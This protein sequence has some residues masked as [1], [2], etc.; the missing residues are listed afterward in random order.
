MTDTLKK[1][2]MK[3]AKQMEPLLTVR[4]LEKFYGKNG[5]LSKALDGMNM[6]IEAG[7]FVGVMGP[8]DRKSVV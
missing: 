6:T 2:Q 5:A 4:E 3:G 8:S 1:K 7:E